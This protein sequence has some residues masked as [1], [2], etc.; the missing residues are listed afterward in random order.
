MSLESDLRLW[1][2]Q[3]REAPSY[4]ITAFD[5]WF[6]RQGVKEADLLEHLNELQHQLDREAQEVEA[7]ADGCSQTVVLHQHWCLYCAQ[8]RA[9]YRLR[10]CVRTGATPSATLH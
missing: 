4:P 10:H 1:V 3:Y 9:H 2:C 6:K 5:L 7:L 8:L